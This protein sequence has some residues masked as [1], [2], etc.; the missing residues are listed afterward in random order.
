MRIVLGVLLLLTLAS[1]REASKIV[2]VGACSEERQAIAGDP[3]KAADQAVARG[4]TRLL[5]VREY[6]VWAPGATRQLMSQEGYRVLPNTS[7][8]PA[9]ASCDYY[10]DEAKAY[11]EGYNRRVLQRSK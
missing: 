2:G 4:D 11:A 7:D 5:A 9:D 6:A 8:N 1:C 3:A 10:Q